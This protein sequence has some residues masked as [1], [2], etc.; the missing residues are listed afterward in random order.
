VLNEVEESD[1]TLIM[2]KKAG[3]VTEDD[4]DERDM[5]NVEEY[6]F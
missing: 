3:I 4:N 5:F 2:Q 6:A 1:K